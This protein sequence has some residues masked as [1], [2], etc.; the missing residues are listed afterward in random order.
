MEYFQS[1]LII[2]VETF[3][4]F[5]FY[6]IFSKSKRIRKLDLIWIVILSV[7]TCVATYLFENYFILKESVIICCLSVTGIFM[8]KCN[9][10][11]ACFISVLFVFLLAIADCITIVI[12]MRIIAIDIDND[13]FINMLLVLMS[14]AVLLLIIMVLRKITNKKWKKKL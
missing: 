4:F 14:K 8:K 6:D 3:C 11:K 2:L 9:Y 13:S 7:V 10:K 1:Y 5:L 12:A